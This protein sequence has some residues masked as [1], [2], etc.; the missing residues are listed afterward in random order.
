MKADLGRSMD[1]IELEIARTRARLADGADVLAGDLAPPRLLEKGVAMLKGFLGRSAMG[2]GGGVRADPVALALIGLGVG[3]LVAENTGLLD[4]LIRGRGDA[5]APSPDPPDKPAEPNGAGSGDGWFRQAASVARGALRSA[6]DR[7]GAAIERGGE[8][9]AHPGAASDQVCRAGGRMI[10]T[11][12]RSPLLLGLAGLAA[13]AAIAMFLPISRRERE[14]AAR[15]RD[16][17]WDKAE[18]LGHRTAKS[19]R[20]LG[21]GRASASTDC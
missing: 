20:D 9:L 1:E 17:L 21:G 8:F 16:D 4:G 7:G 18:E 14:I 6:G 11:V 3:W 2:V 12:E 15:A 5:A 19:I 13:G 10:V